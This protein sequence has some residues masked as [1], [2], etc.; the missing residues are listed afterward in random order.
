MA[1]LNY[2]PPAAADPVRYNASA[3]DGTVQSDF[4]R[5]GEIQELA[6]SQ[7]IDYSVADFDEFKE[8]LM[9]YVKAVYPD[10]Y[11]NFVQSDLGVVFIELFAYLA[12]VLSLK[13]DFLANE[14]YLST[15]KTPENL[16]KVLELIGVK[17]KGPIAS[18]ATALVTPESSV[19]FTGGNTLTI[20]SD[21]RTVT[22]TSQRD[23]TQLTYTLYKINKAT[24]L[25]DEAT[26]AQTGDL[27]LDYN[28][29]GEGSNFTGLVLL[30]GTYKTLEGTF[31]TAQSSKR[32]RVPD[33]SII[34]GSVFVSAGNEVYSEIQSLSLASGSTDAVFEK[35]YNDDYSCSLLFGDDI[36]G[37][38]PQNGQ[39]YTVVY[40]VGGGNRG[41][42]V[43]GAIRTQVN[44]LKNGS[45]PVECTITNT[46]VAAG[47]ANAE[48]VAHA[49]K[50]A[51]YFFRTQYR[52]VTGED[53]TAIANSYAGTTGQTGKALAVA[54]Q[55]GAGGNMIDI[56]V[57]AKATDNQLQRAS[58][59]FKSDLLNH[60]NSYKMITD[61]L[62]IVDG[63]V[64][65][66][67]LV[68]TVF[69]DRNKLALQEN[70]KADVSRSITEYLSYDSMDFGKALR[71]PE[72]ANF[73]MNNPDVRFFKV[74]NYDEDIFVNFNEIIQLNNFEL[75]FEFV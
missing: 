13:A 32:I 53:Y 58:L 12:S 41:D 9:D 61:E 62:T 65:T 47:G 48:S 31:S 67:D 60:L 20:P 37:K 30:E 45:I 25:I 59:P 75:N 5:L 72:L 11:N 38:N 71:F 64:R 57:L 69:V 73:V 46:T 56:Y 40:R 8:A 42:I 1:N 34:E 6:K 39:D 19:S 68:A 18:K 43:E 63:L 33:P 4:M 55:S 74:T 50:Y 16:R 27:V 2:I 29:Y 24:G 52:A 54:R 28:N 66:V 35:I 14:S 15:V 36:R 70:V 51:P 10:D 44:G 3:F 7:L 26:A 23:N 49:K 21:Q 22:T 17:M